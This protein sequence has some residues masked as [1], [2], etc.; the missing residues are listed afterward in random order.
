MMRAKTEARE[1]AAA[2]GNGPKP[3]EKDPS[4]MTLAE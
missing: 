4:Q 3:K 2:E 1:K